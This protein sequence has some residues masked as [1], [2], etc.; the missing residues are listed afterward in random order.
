MDGSEIQIF[1]NIGR[2]PE[3]KYTPQGKMVTEFSVGVSVGYGEHKRTDW[4]KAVAWEK[5]AELIGKMCQKGTTIWLRGTPKVAV[6]TSKEGEA[7]G[8]IE[9]S[10]RDWRILKGGK[11]REEAEATPYDGDAEADE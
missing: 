11:P 7:K 9:I 4:F 10:I 1:G 3:Q 6:W 8:Q 2:D 5:Q